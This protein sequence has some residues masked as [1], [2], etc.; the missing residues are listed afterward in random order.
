VSAAVGLEV[1][2]AF[3]SPGLPHSSTLVVEKN[4]T[5]E[6]AS[7]IDGSEVGVDPASQRALFSADVLPPSLLTVR[8]SNRRSIGLAARPDLLRHG[9]AR[10]AGESSTPAPAPNSVKAETAV[11]NRQFRREAIRAYGAGGLWLPRRSLGS[12]GVANEDTG[13][14][15]GSATK[16]T[17]LGRDSLLGRLHSS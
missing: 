6:T 12:C 15:S 9:S 7:S 5:I 10:P 3:T 13:L 17:G 2:E 14:D 4:V 8:G 1:G 11:T 16:A